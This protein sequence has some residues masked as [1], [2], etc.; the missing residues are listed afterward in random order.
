MRTGLYLKP[1][2]FTNLGD[3][4]GGGPPCGKVGD[5]LLKNRTELPRETNPGVAHAL[6]EP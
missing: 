2:A 6:F 3:S 4:P 5:V 1:L